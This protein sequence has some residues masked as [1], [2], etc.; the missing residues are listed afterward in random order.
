M[1]PCF[2]M[3]IAKI[4]DLS[5]RTKNHIFLEFR[6]SKTFRTLHRGVYVAASLSKVFPT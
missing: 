6:I 3:I 1:L 5:S 4:Q 2:V